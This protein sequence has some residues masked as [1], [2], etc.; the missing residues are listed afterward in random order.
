MAYYKTPN[1]DSHKVAF[2]EGNCVYWERT[3]GVAVFQYKCLL[4]WDG[5]NPL[6]KQHNDA[7]QNAINDF[8]KERASIVKNS[9]KNNRYRKR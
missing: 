2:V 3:K 9:F 7:I 1:G 6:V 5:S 4:P 8:K